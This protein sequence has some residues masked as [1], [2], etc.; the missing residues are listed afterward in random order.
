MQ[1]FIAPILAVL[2]YHFFRDLE[3][4]NEKFASIHPAIKG[5][6]Y[7]VLMAV[8]I[9]LLTWIFTTGQHAITLGEFIGYELFVSAML[10]AGGALIAWVG[11][12]EK[13]YIAEHGKREYTPKQIV[14][15]ILLTIAG[16]AA[17]FGIVY[18]LDLLE[19]I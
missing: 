16:F 9:G 11:Y 6:F 17:L 4:K 3:A 18:L 12:K 13:L 19:I 5:G 14:L 8:G 1:R 15:A 10:G 7:G 2:V